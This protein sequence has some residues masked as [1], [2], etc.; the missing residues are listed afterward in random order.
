MDRE[1]DTP[2]L[3][4][5]SEQD[6]SQRS[7]VITSAETNSV[8]LAIMQEML[9]CVADLTKKV[10]QRQHGPDDEPIDKSLLDDEFNEGEPASKRPCLDASVFQVLSSVGTNA[11]TNSSQ[12][13]TVE[14]ALPETPSSLIFDNITQ[15]LQME[16]P[17]V[18][19]VLDQ[20]ATIANNLA[21]E[22]LPNDTLA[23][24]YKLYDRL[25]NCM[26]LLTPLRSVIN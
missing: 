11:S 18:P 19:R 1:W 13:E 24:K 21:R 25:E 3:T 20:L 8:L 16:T 14:T 22:K 15:E 10:Y 2:S 23:S 7:S 6:D 4:A 12:V 17:C 9:K 5:V 26:A